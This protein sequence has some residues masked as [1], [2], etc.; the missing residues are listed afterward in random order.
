MVLKKSLFLKIAII[1]IWIGLFA[2]LLLRDYN[3]KTLEQRETRAL[4]LDREESY[5]GI[6]LK[7]ERIGFVRNRLT[8]ADKGYRLEQQAR[9]NL[10]IL[11]EYHPVEMTVD[12]ELS[13]AFILKKFDFSMG[14]PFYSMAAQ[15]EVDGKIVRF[16]LTTGKNT[17][18]DEVVL[19]SEPYLAINQRS[20]LLEQGLEEGERIKV[21]YFDPLTLTGNNTIM[22]Y[23]GT[24]KVMIKGRIHILHHF[25]EHFSGVRIN[26]WL[27]NEGRV[28][29]E[30][31]PAGFVMLAEP[32]FKA[33][34]IKK[35]KADLLR[36]VSVPLV[37]HIPELAE[38]KE[39]S[40]RLTVPEETNFALDGDRQRFAHGIVTL[41][42]E[43]IPADEAG[44]CSGQ[45][46]FLAATPFVQSNHPEIRKKAGQ[47]I[48]DET[49]GMVKIR[50][51]SRWVH[52]NLEKRPV[53]TVPDALTTLQQGMG[54]CNEHA[55]LFAALARSVG[56]PVRIVAG[57]TLLERAFYYHAWN[58]VCV[59]GI[60]ISLDTTLNQLPADLGHI[61]FVSGGTREQIKISALLGQLKIEVLP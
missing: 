40:F 45:E 29:K 7:N 44:P 51:L 27:D 2:V 59:D 50:L 58:E 41:I 28:I 26:S 56:I 12:A 57:V 21:G 13:A 35:P 9:L 17:L 32:E 49:R 30:E 3:V 33:T 14:S 4:A 19:A 18:T 20:Y 36:V 42:K 61:R 25:V 8:P 31:S 47:V 24:Q 38:L 53:I 48:K 6:Y 46:D 43:E 55:V 10:K 39:I 1:C 60:W 15:G 37:G 22:E 54:D 52:E 5:A 23:K 16:T 34:D 11:N